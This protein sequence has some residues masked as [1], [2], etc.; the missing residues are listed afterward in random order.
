M[1]EE[2]D[3]KI[4]ALGR[5]ARA[6]QAALRFRDTGLPWAGGV[7]GFSR[8]GSSSSEDSFLPESTIVLSRGRSSQVRRGSGNLLRPFFPGE[9]ESGVL[10]RSFFPGENESRVLRRM[11]FPGEKRPGVL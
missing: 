2:I 3:V 1:A 6:T 11:F 8:P 5:A 10:L 4:Q 7:E 9:N